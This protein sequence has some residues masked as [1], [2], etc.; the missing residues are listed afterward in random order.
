[1]CTEFLNDEQRDENRHRERDDVVIKN[2]RCDAQTLN[3][4]ENRNGRRD[5]AVAV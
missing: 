1:M 4:A 3:S 2:W 5:H